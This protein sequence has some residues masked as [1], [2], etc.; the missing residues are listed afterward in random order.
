M[1]SDEIVKSHLVALNQLDNLIAEMGGLCE[2]QLSQ[3]IEALIKRDMDLASH[4]VKTDEK[5]DEME[6]Q[7]D[8]LAINLMALQQPMAED[9]RIIIAS[10]K[11]A[12][13]LER[14]GDYAKNVAKRATTLAQS[15]Y[16]P[17]VGNTTN[18][19]ARMAGLVQNMIKKVLDAYLARDA[20]SADD[21]RLSDEDVDQMHS[22]LFRE[23]LTYMVEDPRSI[24]SCTH[25][26]FIAKNIERVGDHITNIA[27][28]IIFVVRGNKPVE[29]R[30]K[31]D[32]TSFTVVS[33]N[34]KRKQ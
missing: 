31:C 32:K 34:T 33:L 8:N 14:V 5:I 30:P 28:Q 16:I 13:N 22:S 21:I 15:T 1:D 12:S 2:V 6:H 4:V 23:L 9:L 27:E 7:V 11:V 25:L 24:S 29:E 10:L 3:A 17:H 26:L 19:I 20:E 18:T